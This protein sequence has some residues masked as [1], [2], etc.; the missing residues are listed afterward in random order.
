MSSGYVLERK[1]KQGGEIGR[2][3]GSSLRQ[4]KPLW[5]ADHWTEQWMFWQKWLWGTVIWNFGPLWYRSG[6]DIPECVQDLCFMAST[7]EINFLTILEAGSPWS[8]GLQFLF[9]VIALFLAFR[10]PQM[11][12]LCVHGDRNETERMRE[13][14]PVLSSVSS[15]KN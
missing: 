15:W 5:R 6:S 4:W 1:M 11:P 2:E 14:E 12:F 13:G 7:A 9:L 10:Q 3:S 8:R